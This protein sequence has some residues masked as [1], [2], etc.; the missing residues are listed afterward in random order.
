M[1]D[2]SIS[3]FRELFPHC[4]LKR[5]KRRFGIVLAEST[6]SSVEQTI[7]AQS[8]P[9]H[10]AAGFA[11]ASSRSQLVRE[12]GEG[13]GCDHCGAEGNDRPPDLSCSFRQI[14]VRVGGEDDL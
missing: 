7:A 6:T 12:A 8:E 1:C 10:H 11:V 4:C 14:G 2:G 5:P 13:F 3:H 9:P